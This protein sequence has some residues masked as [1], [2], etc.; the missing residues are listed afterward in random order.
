M[1]PNEYQRLPTITNDYQVFFFLIG[2]VL[3]PIIRALDHCKEA[4]A[5]PPPQHLLLLKVEAIIQIVDISQEHGDWI[6][7]KKAS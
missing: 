6:L 1:I 7:S 5:L 4:G 3:I 2:R